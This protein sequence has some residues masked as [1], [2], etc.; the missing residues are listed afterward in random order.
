M[1]Y[2]TDFDGSFELAEPLT[3]AQVAYLCKFS[4]TRRMK[5][6]AD[7]A[8]LLPDP[9]R[10]AVGLPIGKDG[11]YFVGGKG[12]A[13]QDHD[14]SIIEYNNPPSTQPGLWCHW[15]P[16]EFDRGIIVWDGG[17]KFYDYIEWLQYLIKNFLEPWGH[18]INGIVRWS[19]EDKE[20]IGE[21]V[22]SNNVVRIRRARMVW[23]DE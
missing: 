3:A 10:I 17:E 14:K 1:G 4:E 20:D 22:V 7:K 2:T 5:R 16:S 11:E 19:G 9:E 18:T 23:D 15:T 6:D 12:H 13:G 8:A 21:I